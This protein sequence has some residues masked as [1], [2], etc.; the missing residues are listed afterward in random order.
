[1][2]LLFSIAVCAVLLPACAIEDPELQPCAGKCDGLGS[3]PV[4]PPDADDFFVLSDGTD[5]KA[6]DEL[7]LLRRRTGLGGVFSEQA[8]YEELK[9]DPRIHWIV[10]DLDDGRVIAEAATADKNVYGASVSKALVVGALLFQNRGILDDTTWQEVFRLIVKSD[11]TV[12]TPLQELAGGADAVDEFTRAMGYSS[13]EGSRH[14]NQ[15]NAREL[16]EFLS[17]IHNQR[18]PGAEGLLKVMTACRTGASKSQKYLPESIFLGGKTGTWMQWSHD[19]RFLEIDG[20]RYGVVV[21]TEAGSSELV[22]IMFGGLV[23]EHL[24]DT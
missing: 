22:A 20:K 12:W 18:F 14:G 23:R 10:T 5:L 17:D 13:T 4:P 21:L 2:R 8:T 19:M 16:A 1:M 7:D 11:N 9:T 6:I 15:L 3:I 24:L